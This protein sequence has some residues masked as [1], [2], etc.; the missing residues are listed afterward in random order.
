MWQITPQKCLFT[1]WH[2][3]YY[4]SLASL[5]ALLVWRTSGVIEPP[6]RPKDA[7][8]RVVIEPPDRPKGELGAERQ[9][10][11]VEPPDQPEDAEW[12]VVIEPPERPKDELDAEPRAAFYV[13]GRAGRRVHTSKTCRGLRNAKEILTSTKLVVG[14]TPYNI[15]CRGE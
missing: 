9:G 15:C 8:G 13:T 11:L 7:E 4:A 5:L 3:V 10:D 14:K 2:V 1:V 6:E 12:Q